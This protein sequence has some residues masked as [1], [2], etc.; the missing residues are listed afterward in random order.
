MFI[1]RRPGRSTECLE[2]HRIDKL[3][4]DDLLVASLGLYGRNSAAG[5]LGMRVPEIPC[6]F[7]TRFAQACYVCATGGW[8]MPAIRGPAAYRA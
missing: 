2:V 3:T 8:R 6:A 1:R 5:P 7:A 4:I